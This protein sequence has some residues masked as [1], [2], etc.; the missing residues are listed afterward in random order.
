[1]QSCRIPEERLSKFR[2]SLKNV[3]KILKCRIYIKEGEIFINSENSF[4]EYI[5]KNVVVAFGRGFSIKDALELCNENKYFKVIELKDYVN[6][7]NQIR[8]V[9]SRVIGRKGKVKKEIERI[10]GAKIAIYGKTIALIGSEE[11]IRRA[12]IALVKIIVGSKQSKIL[13]ALEVGRL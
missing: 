11:E 12:E 1:M 10:T 13:R 7:K 8:R 3:E 9:K 2:E 4:N 6:N 5:A